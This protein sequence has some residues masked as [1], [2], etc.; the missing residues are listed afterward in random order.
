MKQTI[1]KIINSSIYIFLFSI[2]TLMSLSAYASEP[3]WQ[4]V[5]ATQP[6]SPVEARAILEQK[7][8]KK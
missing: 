8:V 7:D 4:I 1:R 6:V 3:G 2:V 5:T